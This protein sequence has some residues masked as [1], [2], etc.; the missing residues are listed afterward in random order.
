ME[1][2]LGCVDPLPAGHS[3]GI[4]G[5]ALGDSPHLVRRDLFATVIYARQPIPPISRCTIFGLSRIVDTNLKQ[6]KHIEEVNI[7]HSFIYATI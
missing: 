7:T 2:P 5:T 4:E 3:L 1:R 6:F